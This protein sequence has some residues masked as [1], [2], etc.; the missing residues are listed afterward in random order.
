VLGSVLLVT[1]ALFEIDVQVYGWRDNAIQSP[2]WV[3]G[4]V[5][6]VLA[7]HLCFA[8]STTLLWIVVIYRALKNFASPPAPGPHS[9]WHKRWGWIAAIDMVCTSITGWAFYWLAFA[10]K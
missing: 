9:V 3:D 6:K 7:V 8:V 5:T 10:V 2:Y 1:V 4:T